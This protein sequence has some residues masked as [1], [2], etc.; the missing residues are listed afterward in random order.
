MLRAL[1]LITVL[2]SARSVFAAEAQYVSVTCYGRDV[3]SAPRLYFGT[4]AESDI[5]FG[6]QGLQIK[7]KNVDLAQSLDAGARQCRDYFWHVSYTQPVGSD[8]GD[9]R[10]SEIKRK[11][12]KLN[13]K[14]SDRTTFLS[15]ATGSTVESFADRAKWVDAIGQSLTYNGPDVWL[16]GV[17][18]RDTVS[19]A[20]CVF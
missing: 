3:E 17:W 7:L 18:G 14:E 10:I 6:E 4:A 11:W 19:D 8:A 15:C 5:Q 13:A 2:S 1:F 12:N 9:L 16:A 20:S